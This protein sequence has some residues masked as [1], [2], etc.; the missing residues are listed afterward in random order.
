MSRSRSVLLAASFAL[1]A[2]TGCGG[3]KEEGLTVTGTVT[4]DGQPIPVGQVVFEIP[5]STEQRVGG[6]DKGKFEVKGV[7]AGKVRAAVRTS[8]MQAQY[9][10]SQQFASKAGGK[11]EK[12]EFIA[13]PARYEDVGKA[14]LE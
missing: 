14:N 10:A 13:V 11:A 1:L 7:P 9:A 4:L 2:F 8:M 6:I 3:S 12:G 5:N